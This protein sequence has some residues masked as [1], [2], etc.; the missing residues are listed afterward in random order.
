MR[1]YTVIY[2]ARLNYVMCYQQPMNEVDGNVSRPEGECQSLLGNVTIV[3][4]DNVIMINQ[5]ICFHI[6][7]SHLLFV[8]L[9]RAEME[10]ANEGGASPPVPFGTYRTCHK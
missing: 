5:I 1:V 7:D 6:D 10:I 9:Y 3:L 8:F 2:G 4:Y